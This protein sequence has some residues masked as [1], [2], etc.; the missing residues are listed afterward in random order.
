ME[1]ESRGFDGLGVVLAAT[2]LVAL[3]YGVIEGPNR[4]WTDPVTL[5]CL[6]GRSCVVLAAFLVW[7]RRLTGAIPV[8]DYDVWAHPAFRWG[9]ITAAVASMSL[10]GV[11]FTMPQYFRLVLGADSL[12]TGLRTL[13][14]VLGMLVAMQLSNRFGDR[15]PARVLASVGLGA[16]RGGHGGRRD[17]R[18]G[19][20]LR[21]AAAWTAVV[22]LGFGAALFAAQ[23]AAL[24]SLPRTRAGT[25]SALVQTLR[26]VGSVLGIAVLGAALNAHYSGAGD[27]PANFVDGMDLALWI[28]AGISVVAAVIAAVKLP[29]GR[30]RRQNQS[31]TTSPGLR[32]R[33]KARTRATIQRE[34][35]RLFQRDGYAA[36]SVEAIA[37]AAEVSPSTFFR[38]FPTK[39]D[40]VLS[41]FVD[42]SH[43]RAVRGRAAGAGLLR[44]AGSRRPGRV[45]GDAS[46]RTSS[47]RTVRN[48]LI[49]TVPELRR[50]MIAEMVRPMQLLAD[51][52]GRRTGREVDDDIRMFAGAAVGALLLVTPE[53]HSEEP[54]VANH[55]ALIEDIAD[56]M[57]RLRR[58]LTLPDPEQGG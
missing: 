5:A 50:G 41:D 8:F 31:V 53:A 52:I 57:E 42:E 56:R 39:E 6:R 16:G 17:H 12:G 15:V 20:R 9:S 58:L 18:A 7:E 27:T 44:R 23:T 38:Y 22:G 51:A 13:P 35:L 10:F 14:L 32:E 4:G 47:S 55:A 3:T 21:P 11:F 37:A 54:V 2:G 19:R 30:G 45:R 46:R 34:A 1:Q 26:Q 40:V 24:M 25:G 28:S 36:T 29:R 43:D 48:N 33:K 49:R